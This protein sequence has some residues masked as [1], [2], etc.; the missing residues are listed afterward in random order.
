MPKLLLLAAG[1]GSL[2]V[3][4]VRLPLAG[5]RYEG[6]DPEYLVGMSPAARARLDTRT[7]PVASA[8]ALDMHFSPHT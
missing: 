2:P 4:F 6:K 7:A 5:F 8:I 1:R 3:I